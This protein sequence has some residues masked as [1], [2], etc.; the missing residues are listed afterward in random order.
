MTDKDNDPIQHITDQRQALESLIR[1]AQSVHNQQSALSELT[2]AA[3]P[4][5]DFP[6][7]VLKYFAAIEQSMGDI[8]LPDILKKLETIEAVTE[9]DLS[10]IIHLATLDFNKLRSDQILS[11]QIEN[12]DIDYFVNAIA[13]F[14]RRTQTALAMRVMLSKRGV[15]I[16]PFNIPI[17]QEKLGREI[18]ALKEKEAQCVGQIKQE[19]NQIITSTNAVLKQQSLSEEMEKSLTDILLNM[20]ANLKHLDAGG[21]ITEIPSTF[22]IVTLESAPE[23]DINTPKETAPCDGAEAEQDKVEKDLAVQDEQQKESSKEPISNPT[24]AAPQKREQR[25]YWWLLKRWMLSPW[26]TSWRSLVEKHRDH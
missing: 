4:S 13:D 23:N 6:P 18:E 16:Q 21:L 5:Q 1:I 22:E 3:K 25:S 26:K 10:K 11:P 24:T 2:L 19:I 15:A 12:I 20:K 8:P 9:Q 17:S 14:K 7:K